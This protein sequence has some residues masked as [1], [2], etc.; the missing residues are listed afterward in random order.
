MQWSSPFTTQR[1]VFTVD[2]QILGHSIEL[3]KCIE[4]NVSVGTMKISIRSSK[5]WLHCKCEQS[6]GHLFDM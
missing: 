6:H 5:D 4:I 2:N 1:P 3:C